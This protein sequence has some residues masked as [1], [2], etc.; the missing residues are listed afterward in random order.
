MMDFFP[1]VF[2]GDI[3]L[4][5][6]VITKGEN[7]IECTIFGHICSIEKELIPMWLCFQIEWN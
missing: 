2:K 6:H 1:L 7:M 3:F 4:K 5:R